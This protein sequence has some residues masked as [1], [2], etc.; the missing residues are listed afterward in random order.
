MDPYK[1]TRQAAQSAR[2]QNSPKDITAARRSR[3]REGQSIDQTDGG[4]DDDLAEHEAGTP[5]FKAM[6]NPKALKSQH[7]GLT[8]NDDK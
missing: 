8:F 5:S 2:R 3:M 1:D 6:V 7:A 4:E